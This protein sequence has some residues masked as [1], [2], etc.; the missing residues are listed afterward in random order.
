MKYRYGFEKLG[1]WQK[2]RELVKDIYLATN[3]FPSDEKF[4]LTSQLR[5][6]IISVSSNIAEGS[7]RR[8]QK[9]QARFY[10]IAFGSLIEV[11]NQLILAQDLEYLD[12]NSVETIRPKIDDIGRMLN[13][14]RQST[15][16]A[17][18]S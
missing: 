6:A 4:G 16:K 15:Y 18:D 5:R 1:V 17:A 13:A 11:L 3:Q 2:S 12:T 9:D 14:L 8:G 10:E 7:S